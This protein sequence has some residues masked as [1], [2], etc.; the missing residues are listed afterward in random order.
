LGFIFDSLQIGLVNVHIVYE[1]V[2][3][4]AKMWRPF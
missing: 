2:S 4:Q 3:N 1:L